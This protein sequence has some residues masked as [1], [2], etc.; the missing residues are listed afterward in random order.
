MDIAKW[1]EICIYKGNRAKGQ[2]R[3][4]EKKQGKQ[5]RLLTR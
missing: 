1:R 4:E 5:K 3:H 2:R